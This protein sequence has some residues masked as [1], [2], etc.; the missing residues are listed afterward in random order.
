MSSKDL[1]LA[2]NL[3]IGSQ[4]STLGFVMPLELFE[5]IRPPLPV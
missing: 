2:I 5:N 1:K 3:P 4:H